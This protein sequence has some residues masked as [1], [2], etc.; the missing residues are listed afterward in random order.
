MLRAAEALSVP[1]GKHLLLLPQRPFAIY[2]RGAETQRF[3]AA[4]R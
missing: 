1:K 4:L 3:I 2:R